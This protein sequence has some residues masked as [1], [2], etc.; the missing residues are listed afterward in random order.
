LIRL[1]LSQGV[2]AAA[3]AAAMAAAEE[4]VSVSLIYLV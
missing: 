1:V 4:E 2:E 3:M